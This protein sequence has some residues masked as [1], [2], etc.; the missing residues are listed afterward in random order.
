MCGRTN[1][2]SVGG[3]H[4]ERLP[5]VTYLLELAAP[6]RTLH[7]SRQVERLFGFTEADFA[8]GD[9]F[10]QKRIVPAD[11]HILPDGLEEL[12]RTQGEM[13]VEYRVLAADGREIA[14]RDTA[15][16]AEGDDGE[17]CI[18]GFLT[19]VTNEKRLEREL[20]R[21]RAQADA[22]FR[23]SAVGMGITDAD[24]RYARVNRA[25]AEFTGVA[26]NAHVGH[27]LA[28]ISPEIAEAVSGAYEHVRETGEPIHQ[29][30]IDVE[31][32]G[33]QKSYLVSYFP[34]DGPDERRYGRVVVD[35]TAQRRAEERYRR[36]IEQLPLVTYV[37][38]L[39]P[40]RRVQFVSPQIEALYGYSAEEWLAN[41]E[42][43]ERVVHPDDLE[44]VMAVERAARASGDEVTVQYRI[45]RADGSIRWVLD[46][47][48]TVRDEHGRPLYEQGFIV[49]VTDRYQSERLFRSVFESSLESNVISDDEGRFVDVNAAACELFGRRREELLGLGVGDVS[50]VAGYSRAIWKTLLET[51]ESSGT[52][53]VARPDGE[54]REIE[55]AAKAN[56]LPGRHLSVARDVT[57]RK[58]LERELWRALRLETVGR[59]AGGIAHD[60]NNIL[61]TVR[62]HAQLLA[63]RSAPG[64]LERH[65][66]EE[67]D[68]AA[69]RA[70][71]LTEQLLAFGRRQALQ[72]RH[73][74]VNELVASL[75]DAIR[76]TTRAEVEFDL[77]DELHAVNVDPVQL[78]QVLLN[79][80][81]NAADVTPDRG[82]IVVRTGTAEVE[83]L[84]D[85]P[86]GSYV[87][88]SVEDGGPGI[89]ATTLEHLFE[90]FFTT[91]GVGDGSGLGLATA[92][93]I[94][95][96]SG[97]TI[98]VTTA[99]G[100]GAT[101]AVY[102]RRAGEPGAPERHDGAGE[103][104][105]A[106]EPDPA[107]RHSLFELLT[108]S[109]YRPVTAPSASGAV[110]LAATG[111]LEI[112]L[113][114]GHS[115]DGRAAAIAE[116]VGATRSLDLPQRCPPQQLLLE[117]RRAL[118]LPRTRDVAHQ[119]G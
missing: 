63:A 56:V 95:K 69:T 105:L 14:V 119:I 22:F 60:F 31:V 57:E 32:A 101:F 110:Q 49:D 86:T 90:P 108:D 111:S 84:D 4:L 33:E 23:D 75:A 77:A 93:G 99:K 80:V 100:A 6:S 64:T 51:G 55:Y 67:I 109:G 72:P 73:V 88:L 13:T 98:A 76:G 118:D 27:T 47:M 106:I 104:V 35:I 16:V 39:E 58:Q 54:L 113:V 43:S 38:V 52:L 96:Q 92:Y 53:V 112:D 34:I 97:G 42:L 91:K 26:E 28:E 68:R 8:S 71:A 5:L 48:V 9:D 81:E 40:E 89:D 65:H 78:E 94:V 19:D 24:G 87:V 15:V 29:H 37:N 21:E 1:S 46:R 59:L 41:D 62:G 30:E 114:L 66:V 79:L 36:L 61:T 44:H 7:V 3:P 12:R 102:L 2:V 74:D 82:R 116:A 83:A 11:R 115:G 70:A 107:V 10:W 25:L 85:L 103:V 20:A 50:P 18:H 17:L 45:V 117:V